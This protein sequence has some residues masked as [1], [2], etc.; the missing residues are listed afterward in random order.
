[1]D[2]FS[3]QQA[4]EYLG[5]SDARIRVFIRDGRLK[6]ERVG[7][8]WLIHKDDLEAFARLPR[9]QGWKKGQ[10]RKSDR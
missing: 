6:A 7:R 8:A 10:P 1:M 3:T 9:P 5:V 4:A 2:Y